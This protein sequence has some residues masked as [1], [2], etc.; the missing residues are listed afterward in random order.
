MKLFGGRAVCYGIKGFPAVELLL[1][2]GRRQGRRGREEEK[3]CRD[4]EQRDG[5]VSAHI[6]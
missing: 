2:R 3:Q 6:G 4:K 1:K 5:V